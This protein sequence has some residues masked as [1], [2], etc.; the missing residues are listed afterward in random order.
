MCIPRNVAPTAR[1]NLS[2]MA[3]T[4]TST[5]VVTL[6]QWKQVITSHQPKQVRSFATF[7][8]RPPANKDVKETKGKTLEMTSFPVTYFSILAIF[9]TIVFMNMVYEENAKV[10]RKEPRVERNSKCCG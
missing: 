10:E 7:K 3:K 5:N 1:L 2:K 9:T 4:K 8:C 6:H